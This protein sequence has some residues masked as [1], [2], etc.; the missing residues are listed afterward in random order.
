VIAGGRPEGG[1]SMFLRNI[2]SLATDPRWQQSAGVNFSS[3]TRLLVLS[4]FTDFIL[5]HNKERAIY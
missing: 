5:L 2:S 3:L 4:S 1:G